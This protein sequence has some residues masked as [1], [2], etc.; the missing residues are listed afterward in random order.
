[1]AGVQ[2]PIGATVFTSPQHPDQFCGPSNLLSNGTGANFSGDKVAGRE[3]DHSPP[4]SV[5]VHKMWTYK[6]TLPYAFMAWCLIKHMDNFTFFFQ[7]VYVL[8]V[9]LFHL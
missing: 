9:G 1:M 6:S 8:L 4:A 7:L 2:F 5:Q 3:A